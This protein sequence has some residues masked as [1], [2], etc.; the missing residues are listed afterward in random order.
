MAQV[1]RIK[2]NAVHAVLAQCKVLYVGKYSNPSLAHFHK[3]FVPYRFF[4]SLL[5]IWDVAY[6][7]C[8][9]FLP[10]S[11]IFDHSPSPFSPHHGNPEKVGVM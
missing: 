6:L 1:P 3:F 8:H 9:A 2:G 11:T 5:C 7:N 10:F 4:F